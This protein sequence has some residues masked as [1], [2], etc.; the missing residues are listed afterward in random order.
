MFDDAFKMSVV[1]WFTSEYVDVYS[2]RRRRRDVATKRDV[3]SW[4]GAD[5][6]VP[7]GG[8]EA[9]LSEDHVAEARRQRQLAA[10]VAAG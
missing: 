9:R 3:T 4:Y 1:R 5:A 8:A 6:A 2:G 7:P 10:P